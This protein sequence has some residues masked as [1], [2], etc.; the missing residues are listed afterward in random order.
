MSLT[1][2]LDPKTPPKSNLYVDTHPKDARVR[3]LNIGPVFY[4]GIGL[5]AGR[6]NVEVS[7]NDYE[8]KKLWVTLGSG[9]DRSID[10]RLKKRVVTPSS[11]Y[12]SASKIKRDGQF[13]TLD[14]SAKKIKRD[15]QSFTLYS[16]AGEIKRDGRFVA[17]ANGTVKDTKTGLMWA[18]KDNG[19]DINWRDA[20]RYCENYRGGGYSDWRMPTWDE[21]AGLY[22]NSENYLLE[23]LGYFVHLTK[24]IQLTTCC[25][26]ASEEAHGSLADSHNFSND[27]RDSSYRSS[28]QNHRALPVRSGN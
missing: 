14:S 20:K 10:V 4:Q 5:D 9:E 13:I 17:Y 16:S 8:T 24:L 18:S 25:P 2:F 12:S 19:E 6:Y 28:S 3:I 26:W 1:V 7:A 21:L 15:G 27:N 23:V 11:S 22:D